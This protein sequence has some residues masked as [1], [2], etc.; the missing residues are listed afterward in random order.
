MQQQWTER[1]IKGTKYL[2]AG[3]FLTMAMPTALSLAQGNHLALAFVHFV[4]GVIGPI[5]S[6]IGIY[7]IATRNRQPK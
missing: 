1:A 5:L 4:F 7:F 2:L 3:V 6:V